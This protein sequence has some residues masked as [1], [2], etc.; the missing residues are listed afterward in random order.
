MA[1]R[2][3]DSLQCLRLHLNESKHQSVL[4]RRFDRV[5]QVCD[6]VIRVRSYFATVATRLDDHF[7]GTSPAEPAC[8]SSYG[9]VAR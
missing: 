9:Q 1:N 7:S 2:L 3:V 5:A 4:G 6:D 8:Q